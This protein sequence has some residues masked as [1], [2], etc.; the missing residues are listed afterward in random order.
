MK[1]KG[2]DEKKVFAFEKEKI[3]FILIK[4]QD[5]EIA[6]EKNASGI[7][8]IKGKNY[9]CDRDEVESLINKITLLEIERNIGKVD[10]LG[11]YGLLT[12]EKKI[13]INYDGEKQ[14]LYIG[15]ETPSG[16]YFYTTINKNDV[17]LVYKWDLNNILERK[18]FDLRDKRIIPT[19]IHKSDIEQ[20]EIKKEKLVYL[21]KKYGEKWYIENP[22]KDL[23]SEEQIEK[24]IEN[25]IERKINSFEEK[26]NLKQCGLEN[27]KIIF[28]IKV[29]DKEYF[30]YLGEKELDKYYSKNSLK[31]YIF[32]VDD[33][34]V[35]DI[36]ENI[37]DL[38][39]RKIFD[40]NISDVVEFSIVKKDK[41]LKFIKE[42]GRFYIEKDKKKKVSKDKVNDFLYD[43]KN[44]EIDEF[45]DYSTKKLSE[46]SLSPP[47]V[48]VIVKDEK[49]KIEIDFGKKEKEKIF[50]YHPERKIIFT[51]STSDYEKIDREEEFFIEKEEKKK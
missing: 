35:E 20:I 25:L 4:N 38:R 5:R 18:E 39:E 2:K 1:K 37:D 9:E 40:I 28:R 11:I 31:P 10:D 43:L 30:V 42:K 29:R 34:I 51:I 32:L 17:F 14:T 50:C 24:I 47:L 48:K 7:W 8:I 22:I 6:I 13:E 23:A 36:P 12:T 33:R 26:K 27:P 45:I 49:S 41:E 3:K 44:L 46:F 19:D 16:S 21:F 15:D